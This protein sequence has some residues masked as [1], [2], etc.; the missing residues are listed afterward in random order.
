MYLK[1]KNE[2]CKKT[3]VMCYSIWCSTASMSIQCSLD[4][5]MIMCVYLITM[6]DYSGCVSKEGVGEE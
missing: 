3:N 4:A 2:K 6:F 1:K 5:Q